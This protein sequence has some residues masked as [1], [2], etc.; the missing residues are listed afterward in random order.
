MLDEEDAEAEVD[1]DETVSDVRLRLLPIAL[2]LEG[3]D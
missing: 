3:I 1:D 2:L